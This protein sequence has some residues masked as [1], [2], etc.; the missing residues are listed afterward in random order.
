MIKIVRQDIGDY[1]AGARIAGLS[2]VN[3]YGTEFLMY[4][5]N[6]SSKPIWSVVFDSAKHFHWVNHER[7]TREG[8]IDFVMSST[9]ELADW[10]LFNICDIDSGEIFNVE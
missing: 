2:I 10:L 8:F 6:R 5:P 7:A 9:P 4:N 3:S 1:L